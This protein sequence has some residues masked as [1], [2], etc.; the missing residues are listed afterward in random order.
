MNGKIAASGVE[1]NRAFD[2]T[3]DGIDRGTRLGRHAARRLD[4]CQGSLHRKP[5][6][7]KRRRGA[8]RQCVR[9]AIV[10]GAD[11]AA[12]RRGPVTQR[13][14]PTN[15][16]DLVCR[17][18]IDGYE[19]IFAQIRRSIGANSI[20]DD[21]DAIDVEAPNDRPAGRPGRKFRAGDAGL[22]EQQIAERAATLPAD[23]LVRYY[24]D[25][26]KLIRHDGKHALLGRGS[27]RRRLRLRCAFAVAAGNGAGNAHRFWRRN[28][29]SPHNR[30]WCR[31]RDAWKRR[32]A[33]GPSGCLRIL[34][35]RRAAEC[36]Q[37]ERRRTSG[38]P[39]TS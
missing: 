27:S 31:Y 7:L 36:V 11:H 6:R 26:G 33:F 37:Q 22:G 2:A 3:I 14:G 29:P 28:D 34:G 15:D 17:N 39:R 1:Q 21:P 30:A 35:Q 18:R 38:E 10:A 5:I 25:R 19:V 13:C 20:L 8:G 12:D 16:F 23:F 4:I 9:N 32:G 24:R